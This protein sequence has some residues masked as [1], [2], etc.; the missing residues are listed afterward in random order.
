M[1]YEELIRAALDEGVSFEQI[2]D[3]FTSA[4]NKVEAQNKATAARDT[5]IMQLWDIVDNSENASLEAATAIATI[6]GGNLYHWSVDEMKDFFQITEN[7]LKDGVETWNKA[8]G[9]DT[10]EGLFDVLFNNSKRK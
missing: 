1:N 6:Y 4:L 7:T 8:K 5:Y 3:G 9:I 2:A 10:L